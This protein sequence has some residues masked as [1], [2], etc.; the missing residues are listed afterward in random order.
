[1][2]GFFSNGKSGKGKV[3]AYTTKDKIKVSKGSTKVSIPKPK[4][5]HPPRPTNPHFH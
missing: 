4:V 2:S 3:M 1:M 5:P